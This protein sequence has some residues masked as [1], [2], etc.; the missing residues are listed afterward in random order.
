[1]LHGR[2]TMRKKPSRRDV[3][4]AAVGMAGL[5]G[6]ATTEE[7]QKGSSTKT[8]IAPRQ[9]AMGRRRARRPNA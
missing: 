7:V 4:K 1:M 9:A 2:V 8:I 6:C 5:T 3:I